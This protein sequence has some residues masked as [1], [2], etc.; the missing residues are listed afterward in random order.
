M[1]RLRHEGDQISPLPPRAAHSSW[2]GICVHGRPGGGIGGVV[3][4]PGAE[5]AVEQLAHRRPDPG[6]NVNA[7]GDVADRNLVDGRPGHSSLHI[8]RATSPCRRLTPFEARLI[9]SA[10][11]VT[12]NGLRRVTRLVA[13]QRRQPRPESPELLGQAAATAASI[14]SAGYVSFPAGTGVCVVK[15]V[16]AR[17]RPSASAS[18]PPILRACQLERGQGG[19]A[20]VEMQDAGLVAHRPQRAN[21]A[22]A[23][24]ARTAPAASGDRSHTA[25]R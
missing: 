17:A 14:C 24:G 23:R 11:W 21:A 7:V 6:W 25:G 5:V 20:L 18:G 2:T 4:P 15:T 8:P 16:W 12:P 10:D 19:M 3:G 9:R 1:L 22:D 13:P